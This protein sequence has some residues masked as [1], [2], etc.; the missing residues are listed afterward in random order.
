MTEQT[1]FAD[2]NAGNAS[3]ASTAA[4]AAS[5]APTV[6]HETISEPSVPQSKVNEL[7][8]RAKAEAYEKAKRESQAQ[9][10]AHTTAQ[11]QPQQMGGITQVSPDEI[12]RLVDRRLQQ[13]SYESQNLQLAE[14]FLQK[15]QQGESKYDDFKEVMGTFNL[16]EFVKSAP[17][18]FHMVRDVENTAGVMRELAS[19][20]KKI[21]DLQYTA[22]M[23]PAAAQREIRALSES[24]KVNDAA[25]QQPK[26]KE[27]LAQ[28]KPSTA[29]VDNGS[30]SVSDF[31]NASWLK[32]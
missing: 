31:R 2:V 28:L 3:L 14:D 15:L 21:A 12:E 16:Q 8:G 19:N 24:I 9:Q 22:H 13:R 17:A 29:G 18:V 23:N 30:M 25:R 5:S 26:A 6:S 1:N 10:P 4:P 32:V 27:P 20:P 7:V 11:S